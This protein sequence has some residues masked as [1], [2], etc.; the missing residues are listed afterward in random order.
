MVRTEWVR[1]KKK[2]CHS[3]LP[4]VDWL[5]TKNFCFLASFLWSDNQMATGNWQLAER[6]C[7]VGMGVMGV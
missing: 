1:E 3:K 6:Q 5:K 4:K 7:P 2:L